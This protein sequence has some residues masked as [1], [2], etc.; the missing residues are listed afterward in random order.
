MFNLIRFLYIS[1]LIALATGISW[2][3]AIHFIPWLAMIIWSILT[4]AL[5]AI[6]AWLLHGAPLGLV[7]WR[8]RAAGYLLP[9]GF[10]L[11]RGKL[12][13]SAIAAWLIWVAIG[14][15]TITL[16]SWPASAA[17]S[18]PVIA[19]LLFISW[20]ILGA[21]IVRQLGFIHTFGSAHGRRSLGQSAL[22]LAALIAAGLT[23]WLLRRPGWALVVSGGPIA[24]VGGGYGL[25]LA[26]MLTV[27][28][29]ARW[30]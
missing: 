29:N 1:A 5:C 18:H 11:G 17:T 4:A 6:G 21:L 24:M 16:I 15:A 23:L 13:P 28:R 2:E 30:N 26:V 9:W 12:L 3:L 27:G 19:T 22:A 20:I 8:N 25:F 7:N 14:T 10:K